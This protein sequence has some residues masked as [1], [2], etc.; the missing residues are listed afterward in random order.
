MGMANM[1]GNDKH[2]NHNSDNPRGD[3]KGM[4]MR[5]DILPELQLYWEYF[6]L[7]LSGDV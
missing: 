7:K 2:T 4:Q 5:R 1:Y 6:L 3:G